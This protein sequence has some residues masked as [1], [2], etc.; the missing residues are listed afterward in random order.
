MYGD[1]WE[2]TGSTNIDEG[3]F[4][5]TGNEAEK[6]MFKVPSLRNIEKTGP[7]LHDGSMSDLSEVI[8]VMGKLQLNKNITDEQVKS[9]EIFLN[10]LTGEL[11]VSS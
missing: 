6:Y 11:P 9:I 3:R 1:Y 7:Y 5:V 4:K 8:R 2:L 10:S